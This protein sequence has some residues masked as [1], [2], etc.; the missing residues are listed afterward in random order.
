M[1]KDGD[2]NEFYKK[3]DLYELDDKYRETA[4]KISNLDENDLIILLK[5]WGTP[6]WANKDLYRVK[7]AVKHPE[8]YDIKSV[9]NSCGVRIMDE[10]SG[11]YLKFDNFDDYYRH[12]QMFIQNDIFKMDHNELI[13]NEE[14]QKLYITIPEGMSMRAMGEIADHFVNFLFREKRIK[15]KA[16][17]RRNKHTHEYDILLNNYY[18]EKSEERI[19]ICK[20]FMIELDSETANKLLVNLAPIREKYVKKPTILSDFHES[21]NKSKLMEIINGTKPNIE[22]ISE[23]IKDSFYVNQSQNNH[24]NTYI[25]NKLIINNTTNHNYDSETMEFIKNMEDFINHIKD[26]KPDWYTPGKFIP[27]KLFVDMF[28]EK[29]CCEF[30]TN[31][32]MLILKKIGMKDKIMDDEITRKYC[33]EKYDYSSKKYRGFVAKI[34]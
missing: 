8:L 2:L 10:S 34:L 26:L 17:I 15:T 31:K 13:H 14:S 28:N 30:S 33:C 9:K 25:I 32:F 20:K 7:H 24:G 23:L 6:E 21:T 11:H 29:Y 22:K 18:V 3:S 4:R 16:E 12:N 19:E 1:E 27:K 5:V